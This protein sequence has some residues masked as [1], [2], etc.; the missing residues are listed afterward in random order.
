MELSQ[1]NDAIAAME[2]NPVITEVMEKVA[3][4]LY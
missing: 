1:V 4:A 3:R 2:A